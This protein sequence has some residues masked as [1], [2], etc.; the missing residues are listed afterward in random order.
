MSYAILDGAKLDSADLTFA[1]LHGIRE[2]ETEWGSALRSRARDTDE[3]RWQGE[4][5]FEPPKQAD[6]GGSES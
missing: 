3:K 6:D 2:R 1:N 4:R 5:G